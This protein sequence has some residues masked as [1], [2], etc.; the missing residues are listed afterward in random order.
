M[1]RREFIAWLGSAAAWPVVAQA[2]QAPMPV[3]GLLSSGSPQGPDVLLAAY[4]DGLREQG[5]VEG[6]NVLMTFRR[7]GGRYNELGTLANDRFSIVSI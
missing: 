6:R 3:I 2:Q 7:A 4:R 1:R 5:D